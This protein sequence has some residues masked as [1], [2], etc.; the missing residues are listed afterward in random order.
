M[1]NAVKRD[2]GIDWE[3]VGGR[4]GERSRRRDSSRI[5]SPPAKGR[6]AQ[7]AGYRRPV[8]GLNRWRTR[9]TSHTGGVVGL[10]IAVVLLT[11]VAGGTIAWAWAILSEEKPKKPLPERRRSAPAPPRI[12]RY[13][14]VETQPAGPA[15]TEPKPAAKREMPPPKRKPVALA[16]EFA[17][18]E[19]D[20][21]RQRMDAF[22]ALL[23]RAR[24]LASAARQELAR[25]EELRKSGRQ[26]PPGVR[27]GRRALEDLVAEADLL[28]VWQ[29]GL[30]AHAEKTR[31]R[32]FQVKCPRVPVE[33]ALSSASRLWGLRLEISP[34]GRRL[35][36]ALDLELSG[37]TDLDGFLDWVSVDRSRQYGGILIVGRV[38]ERVVLV[39]AESFRTIA[40]GVK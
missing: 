3:R 5:Y 4:P 13:R 8:G 18:L 21:Y 40:A 17:G 35:L 24:E 26:L 23:P 7:M 11:I 19:A 34:G 2:T 29:R 14:V 15:V 16:P 12:V 1:R 30:P 25:L 10:W 9:G 36:A 38:G 32:N 27:E 31:T 37:S 39:P 28:K 33:D 20:T 22:A 6:A